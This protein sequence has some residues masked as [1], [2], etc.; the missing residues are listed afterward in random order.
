MKV[1]LLK[2]VEKV[3]F[4]GEIIKVKEGFAFNYLVPQKLGVVVTPQNEKFYLKQLKSVEN[5]KEAIST[6]T[7]MLAE[8]IKSLKLVIK[9]KMHDD[10]KLYASISPSD[11]ADL[12]SAEGIKVSKAQVVFEKPIKT[13]GTFDVIIKLSNQL[14][15]KLVLKVT[16]EKSGV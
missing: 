6:K 16:S 15:P 7:S 13:Q 12:L 4:A 11:V 9:R 5:R 1:F 3:G 2:D 10:D 14:Q 8:K